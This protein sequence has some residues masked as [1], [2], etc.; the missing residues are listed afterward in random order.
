VDDIIRILEGL[1]SQDQKDALDVLLREGPLDLGGDV[2]EQ[3]TIFEEMM[4]QVPANPDITIVA[5]ALGGVDVLAVEAPG[6]DA[7]I[8]LYV[9]GG[10][11]AIGTAKSSIPLA[12][13]LAVRAHANLISV[14]YRLAPEFPFP[15]GLDDVLAVYRALLGSHTP[16][17]IV[18]A[19]ESAGAGL[20]ASTLVALR[21]AS[22]P[23]PAAAVLMSPWADLTLGG[24]S[25][26]EKRLVDPAVDPDGLRRRVTDYLGDRDPSSPLASPVFADLSGLPPLLIQAGSHE[27]LLSDATRLAARAARSDVA[28]TLDVVPGVP[29]VF[30]SFAVMLDEASDALDRAAAF[31]A[32][33]LAA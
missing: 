8:I 9:H 12:G 22:D 26:T 19:G 29:H 20:V 32:L 7:D 1:M 6:A 28:T 21:D 23:L 30:Q 4:S 33:H 18:L 2:T 10:A 3:R 15:A 5:Q 16:R 31:I 13:D 17:R 14:D 27:V 11:F 25:I 24:E